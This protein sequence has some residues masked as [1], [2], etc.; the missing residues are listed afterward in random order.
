MRLVAAQYYLS[1][2]GKA[3][4][5]FTFQVFGAER[6]LIKADCIAVEAAWWS[7]G[8]INAYL[9][10]SSLPTFRTQEKWSGLPLGNSLFTLPS[11]GIYEIEINPHSYL[12]DIRFLA[13]A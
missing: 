2:G 7:A 11:M 9:L 4:A 3:I 8:W 1:M 5:P 13:W 10:D 6:L 12:K